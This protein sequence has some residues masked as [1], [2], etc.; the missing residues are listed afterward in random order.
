MQILMVHSLFS[1]LKLGNYTLIHHHF[2]LQIISASFLIV[3]ASMLAPKAGEYEA[4]EIVPDVIDI[5]PNENIQ[6][7]F[8]HRKQSHP[9]SIQSIVL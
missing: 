2:L 5:A 9:V 4:N 8:S 6:V 1:N 3:T 7:G